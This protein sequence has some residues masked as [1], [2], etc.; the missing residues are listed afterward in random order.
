MN[1]AQIATLLKSARRIAVVGI[2][3]KPDRDSNMVARY[4][5]GCGYEVLPVNPMLG[6]WNGLTV[7]PALSSIEGKVDI[8]DLFRRPD[9]VAPVVEEAIA[10]GAGAVWFQFGTMNAE[11]ARKAEE[12]GLVVVRNRCIK[13]EHSALL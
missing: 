6:T 7:Y 11:A 3:D 9:Q 13:V 12:A 10:I 2:S 5:I 8:V 1:D 4:L